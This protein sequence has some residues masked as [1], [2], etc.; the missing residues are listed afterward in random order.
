MAE[1]AASTRPAGQTPDP[2]RRSSGS[3]PDSV[4][5]SL[6]ATPDPPRPSA[7]AGWS[8]RRSNLMPIAVSTIA[9][10]S[11]M[12]FSAGVKCPHSSIAEIRRAER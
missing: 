7:D 2:S 5:P 10:A 1:T 12:T 9:A 3:G 11:A 6:V 8:R 4:S